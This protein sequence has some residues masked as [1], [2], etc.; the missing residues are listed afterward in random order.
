MWLA[1]ALTILDDVRASQ[2]SVSEIE[3]Q[4]ETLCH[5][6]LIKPFGRPQLVSCKSITLRSQWSLPHTRYNQKSYITAAT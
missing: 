4:T 6:I 3:S 5:F 1:T 2:E